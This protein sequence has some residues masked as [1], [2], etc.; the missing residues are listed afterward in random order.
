MAMLA[1]LDRR[2]ISESWSLERR[3]DEF[4]KLA[5]M[6]SGHCGLVAARARAEKDDVIS[7]QWHP[8]KLVRQEGFWC[9]W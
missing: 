3:T 7:Q 6:A 4:G 5:A 9:G 8:G 2:S 1:I